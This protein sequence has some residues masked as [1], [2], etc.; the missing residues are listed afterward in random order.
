MSTRSSLILD[1]YYYY[2]ISD[3]NL[4]NVHLQNFYSYYNCGVMYVLNGI[5]DLP[6]TAGKYA[7]QVLRE[8][9]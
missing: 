7:N 3:S 9:I 8:T 2:V 6:D 4:T 1:A 5:R